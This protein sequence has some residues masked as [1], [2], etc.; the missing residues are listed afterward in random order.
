VEG[1]VD[2][3]EVREVI[4]GGIDEFVDP[5][6]ADGASPP[7][8]NG[9]GGGVV[10]EESAA[11]VVTGAE[12]AVAP[13][14]GGGI[15]GGEDLL[16][17]LADGDLVVVDLGAAALGEGDGAGHDGWDEQG[18]DELLDVVRIEEPSSG[19]LGDQ[20]A[21]DSFARDDE[22][23]ADNADGGDELPAT[24]HESSP[25]GDE[26]RE[27]REGRGAPARIEAESHD[28]RSRCMG[29]RDG[30]LAFKAKIAVQASYYQYKK[31]F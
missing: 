9:E 3:E 4:A 23:G 11:S 18:G 5:L 29:T 6:D 30:I 15:A 10:E 19:R 7:G 22:S 13:D 27:R 20:S 2:G 21:N 16:G 26:R 25:S 28:D 1:G 31:V 17:E 12:C 14:G 8:L 24:D